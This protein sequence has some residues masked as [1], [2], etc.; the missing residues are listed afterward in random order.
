MLKKLIA[1]LLIMSIPALSASLEIPLEARHSGVLPDEILK[2]L[3]GEVNG[4]A[5]FN[6]LRMITTYHRTLG[7]DDSAEVLRRLL[8]KC[9][10]YGL[11]DVSILRVPIRTGKEYF[12]LQNF[13]GQVPMRGEVAELRMILPYP[14]LIATTVSAP[15]CLIQGSR[16]AEVTAPLVFVGKGDDRDGYSGK[17]VKGKLVLAGNAMP[18]DV[19]EM[20]IHKFG[21]AGVLFFF[22]IPGNSGDVPDANYNLHWSPWSREGTP[23]TFGFSLSVNQYKFLKGLIESGEEVVL[24]AKVDSEPKKDKDAVFEALDASIPGSVHPDQEFWLWAH[25]DHSLPGAVDN[26][27]GCAVLLE[28][29][30]AL[31]SLIDEGIFPRP[32]RTIRF[33]WLPHVTGLYMYL[34]QHPEKLGKVMGGLSIDSVGI[35]QTRFSSALMLQPPSHSMSSYWTAV[36]ESLV[37]HLQRRTNRDLFN[38]RDTDN[39]FSPEGSRDQYHVRITPFSSGGDEMQSNNNTVHIP[40]IALGSIPV[41]PRHSQVNFLSYIDPT[42]LQRAAYLTAAFCRTFGWTDPAEVWRICD[43]TASRGRSRLL[44]EYEKAVRALVLSQADS[45]AN[46]GLKGLSLLKYGLER[47]LGMLDSI[48]PLAEAQNESLG[49]IEERK[50]GTK[51]FASLLEEQLKE[52]YKA[53]GRR[54]S[55]ALAE[56]APTPNEERLDR[57]IPVPSDGVMGTSSYYGNYY[58]KVLGKDKLASF[59]LPPDFA[60]GHIGITE[61]HNFIDGLRSILDIQQAVSAEIWSEGYPPENEIT[62]ELAENYMRML[63]AAGV[64]RIK[65]RL[66]KQ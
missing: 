25:Y 35:D 19:K 3:A 59:N 22:D 64:I 46:A 42:G 63:E 41:P 56:E 21:A 48:V 7:S 44:G 18:E 15:S 52:E 34:S 17:S 36:M 39:L 16:S 38:F 10:R 62:L 32:R 61:A 31:Q 27:S 12:G 26:G 50:L 13:D 43:E 20:A 2:V 28:V 24:Q 66:G 55:C 29:A 47:E 58:E 51:R 8:E 65:E 4:Y 45:V 54:L 30:R 57:M 40:T 5:A 23:S 60:Y 1:M 37:E 6:N 49:W 11:S 9:R 33:L 14:K 53:A